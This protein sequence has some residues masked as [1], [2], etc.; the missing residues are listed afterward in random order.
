M[1]AAADLGTHQS[2]FDKIRAAIQLRKWRW[3]PT[4][5]LAASAYSRAAVFIA[6]MA[7]ADASFGSACLGA[8][9]HVDRGSGRRLSGRAAPQLD[10]QLTLAGLSEGEVVLPCLAFGFQFAGQ[11]LGVR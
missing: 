7:V 6:R 10:G 2:V 1:M 3:K 8:F 9:G 5:M 4:L 11:V